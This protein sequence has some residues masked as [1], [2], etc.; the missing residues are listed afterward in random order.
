[1]KKTDYGY[2]ELLFHS[3][4]DQHLFDNSR[5]RIIDGCCNTSTDK[6]GK[7]TELQNRI[8]GAMTESRDPEAA[9]LE[10]VADVNRQL[11]TL[12]ARVAE[13]KNRHY[14]KE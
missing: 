8:E 9:L 14:P 10:S 1:M 3:R 2:H 7:L 13:M 12:L 11:S 4:I 5:R 6:S